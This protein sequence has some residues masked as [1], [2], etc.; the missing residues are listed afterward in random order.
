M[1]GTDELK[2][3]SRVFDSNWVG[4]GAEVAKFEAGFADLLN[5]DKSQV[6]STT[7]CT[8]GLF[9]MPKIF[10]LTEFDEVIIPCISFPAVA[11]AIIE[12]GSKVVFCDVNPQTLNPNPEHIQ[13]VLTEQT[14]AVFVSHYGGVPADIDAIRNVLPENILIIEDAACCASSEYKGRKVGALGDMACWS[15]D[16]MK[17]LSTGDGGMICFRSPENRKMAAEL[18]YLGLPAS[19]KSGL[20]KS[21]G[22]DVAGWWEFDL[23]VPGRRAIMNDITAAM[24]NSQ[25]AKLGQFIARRK[26][27][28]DYYNQN[29]NGIDDLKLPQMPSYEFKNSYYF[30]W[31]QTSRR[32]ELAKY[33]LE[34]GI[35][36]TFRYW[37][38]NRI[39][40]FKTSASTN[41]E[42]TDYA[43]K[44]TLNIPLHQGL[45]DS[46]INFIADSIKDFFKS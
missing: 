2:A 38:L 26:E 36:T 32:D 13:A 19:D 46:D 22:D 30:Y 20:D 37:P 17:T 7:S 6:L 40:L 14:K 3:V 28:F 44:Y 34:K 31:I 35:Y 45:S 15:F 43:S 27:I 10:G 39:D 12:H 16:A 33:L 11:S 18:L 1:L 23:C 24:G 21:K 25:L 41:F 42:G 29:L 4:K 5:V 8:E 9:L